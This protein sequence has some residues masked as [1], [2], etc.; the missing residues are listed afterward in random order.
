MFGV[1]LLC[2]GRTPKSLLEYTNEEYK[3]FIPLKDRAQV[4]YVFSAFLRSGKVAKLVAVV[5]P[6]RMNLVP[7]NV[8]T[9]PDQG[10]ML[11]NIYAALPLMEDEKVIISSAD[12]PLVDAEII[13]TVLSDF[14]SS[15]ADL[16]YPIVDKRVN[17]RFFAKNK[18]TYVKTKDGTFTGGNFLLADRKVV[19]S[20]RDLIARIIA[21]RKN[22]VALAAILGIDTLF[23]LATGKIS[24]P[25]LEERLSSRLGFKIRTYIC[26]YP[27]VAFDLDK[28]EDLKN[29]E[30]ILRRQEHPV[31]IEA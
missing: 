21:N 16:L 15:D 17:D 22:P 14:E 23:A 27:Q 8:I 24:I 18:R 9:L 10:G 4:D 1:I 6:E 28:P 2:G 7:P 3:S 20:Q 5:P 29:I 19:M 12:I 30:E 31:D 13:R 26:K 25:S 11:E